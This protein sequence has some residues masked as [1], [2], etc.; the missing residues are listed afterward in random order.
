MTSLSEIRY[1]KSSTVYFLHNVQIIIV[2]MTMIMPATETLPARMAYTLFCQKARLLDGGQSDAL[3]RTFP[4]RLSSRVRIHDSYF[5]S[6]CRSLTSLLPLTG[7]IDSQSLPDILSSCATGVVPGQVS[8]NA[9]FFLFVD[10]PFSKTGLFV[11]R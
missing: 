8:R 1:S 7:A 11:S 10:K 4:I 3:G 2:D 9:A 6:R 5:Q